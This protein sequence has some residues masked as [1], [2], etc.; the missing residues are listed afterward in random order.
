MNIRTKNIV[1]SIVLLISV[2]GVWFYRKNQISEPIKI[3]GETMATSYHITY[4]DEEKRDFKVSVDSL[5]M[6][7]NKSINNYDPE[8]EI[9]RF[10]RAESS[11]KFSL[12]YLL[13]PLKKS[14]EV[15]SGSH[16]SFDPTVMPLV[17]VW[18]FGPDK[19]ARP[20]STKIDSLKSLVGFEKIQFNSDSVWKLDPRTQ[21]DFGGIGQGY[22]ADVVSDFLKSKGV[23]NFLMELGGEGMACGRN[24][25]KDKPWELGILDPNSTPDNQFFKAYVSLENKSFTTSGNYFNFREVDGRK[26][27]HTIDPESGY[28][29]QQEILSASVFATDAITADAWATAF[30]VMGHKRAFEVLKNHTELDAFLIYSTKDG[31]AT[32]TTEKISQSIRINP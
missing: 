30:M 12:P 23:E 22:G 11:L 5:L 24:L 17:N 13:P 3:E 6:L 2:A 1:Y 4:F 32:F 25:Q 8:S 26:Y 19:K 15:V 27:S 20:D 21:L 16:G 7:V 14:R 28:P 9:S 29:V 31:V 18:G 10:N